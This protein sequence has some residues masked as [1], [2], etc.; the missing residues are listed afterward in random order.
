[1]WESEMPP[2]GFKPMLSG[3]RRNKNDKGAIKMINPTPMIQ[4][5]VCQP[6]LMTP[7]EIKAESST[8]RR[9]GKAALFIDMTKSAVPNEPSVER[10]G[11][12]LHERCR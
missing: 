2:S 4:E 3:D 10:G 8:L 5:V 1:M 7:T 11:G 12:S 9:V 6:R